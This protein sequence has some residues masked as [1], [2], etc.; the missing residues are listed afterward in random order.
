[1]FCIISDS[2]MVLWLKNRSE[3]PVK[4]QDPIFIQFYAKL[5]H[6]QF[7][8][9]VGKTGQMKINVLKG[10]ETWKIPTLLYKDH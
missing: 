6:E 7:R 8:D 1:M 2:I 10:N 4:H 5:K 3:P 9:L